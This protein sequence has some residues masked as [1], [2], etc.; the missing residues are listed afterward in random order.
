MPTRSHFLTAAVALACDAALPR[1]ADARGR[2]P[3]EPGMLDIHHIATGRGSAALIIL[4]DGT[5]L[6]I[7]A[8]AVTSDPAATPLPRPDESRRPGEWIARYVQRALHATDRDLD[9]LVVTNLLPAHAGGVADVLGTIP[10]H[11]VLDRGTPNYDVP[12]LDLPI[13]RF[14]TA[15]ATAVRTFANAGGKVERVH[16]GS[17]TQI[18]QRVRP[19]H[20]VQLRVL[21][22][23]GAVWVPG[24][25]TALPTFAVEESN[26][27]TEA[28]CS[29]ALRVGYGRFAYYTGGD[30]TNNRYGPPAAW[31]DIEGAVATAC[32][33]VDVAVANHHGAYDACGPRFVSAL[34]PRVVILQPSH[35]SHPAPSTLDTLTN[36]ALYA[37]D[38]DIFLTASTPENRLATEA[39][40]GSIAGTD[41]HVVVRVAPGGA[42]YHVDLIDNSDE[43]DTLIRRYGPYTSGG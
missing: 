8:G 26:R 4:P 32:G 29:V 5:S 25:E 30:L 15:Y 28:M 35:V 16:A 34:Q 31:R 22:V 12:V 27:P 40:A 1:R 24:G 38:R 21:A 33:P 6:L 42:T 10:V 37:R 18:E 23:N 17:S 2:A 19:Q 14:G 9:Y 11:R 36:R 7:D 20:D 39:F 13:D 43:S 3:W 41:G